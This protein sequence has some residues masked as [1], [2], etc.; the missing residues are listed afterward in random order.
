MNHIELST[1]Y[2]ILFFSTGEIYLS[3]LYGN[4]LCIREPSE[5]LNWYFR[6]LDYG[7][8]PLALLE[9]LKVKFGQS[10]ADQTEAVY[11]QLRASNVFRPAP[12]KEGIGDE[13]LDRFRSQIA[14]LAEFFPEDG[15]HEAFR[16]IWHA[17]V[18]CVGAG[19][20][21]SQCAVMLAAAGIGKITLIDG[22]H[23]DE[24]NLTR[25]PYYSEQDARDKIS[26]G[27]GAR[28]AYQEVVL[29]HAGRDLGAIPQI[30]G[31]RTSGALR[32]RSGFDD[33]RFAKNSRKQTDQSGMY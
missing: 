27:T 33:G 12:G 1:S 3:D 7:G 17:S 18:A 8:D 11:K 9:T 28:R 22:D 32:A 23:V 24:T 10:A 19:G 21:G 15:G 16:R 13:G 5:A 25:Q 29:L 2:E 26:Q 20:A 14:W 31:P 30:G 6:S 4:N